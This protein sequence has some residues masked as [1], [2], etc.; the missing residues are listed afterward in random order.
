M[1][2]SRFI[3]TTSAQVA[4]R[5]GIT[6]QAVTKSVRK[7]ADKHD[8]PVQRDGRGR[9]THFCLAHYDHLLER[10]G[11]SEKLAP[12]RLSSASASEGTPPEGGS[13]DKGAKVKADSRDEALRQE[14]WLKLRRSQLAME[15]ELGSL[16][17]RDALDAALKKCAQEIQL[18]VGRLPNQADMLA[19]AIAKDGEHGARSELRKVAFKLNQSIADRL[20]EVFEAAPETDEMVIDPES[21]QAE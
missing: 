2:E 6:K 1:D 13:E 8:L 20:Q 9:I 11:N 14:A 12:G 19:Q 3:W 21:Q 17:R 4:E 18:L 5:D 7:F 10:F 15:E 16:V